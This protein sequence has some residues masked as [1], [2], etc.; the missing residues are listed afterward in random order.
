MA[1]YP[2]FYPRGQ[3]LGSHSG[4]VGGAGLTEGIP[5]EGVSRALRRGLGPSSAVLF[6]SMPKRLETH[7]NFRVFPRLASRL[8]A[9]IMEIANRCSGPASSDRARSIAAAESE[10]TV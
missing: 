1:H 9:S 5:R 3:C 10:R 4:H 7:I 6:P 2:L 8:H